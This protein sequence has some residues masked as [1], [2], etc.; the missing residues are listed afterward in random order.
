MFMHIY[1][2]CKAF[3]SRKFFD[4]KRALFTELWNLNGDHAN[5]LK[6]FHPSTT[7]NNCFKR[8]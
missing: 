6:F 3:L 4:L 5:V 7:G 2:I 1:Q 8:I